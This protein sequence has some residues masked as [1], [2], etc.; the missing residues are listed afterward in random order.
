[1]GNIQAALVILN[2]NG[3]HLLERFLPG[4]VKY[5]PDT[6]EIIIADNASTDD[7]VAFLKEHYANI[8]IIRMK[9]NLGY[10]GGYN[11]ALSQ[12]KADI[13]ILLNSDMEVTEGWVEPCMQMFEEH[14]DVGALQPK[15]RSLKK[16]EYF[17]YAGAAGGFI[18]ILGFPFCRGRIFTSL[19]KDTGQF[20]TPAEIFWATGAALFVRAEVFHKPGGFDPRF[21]AHMEEI[22][23]CWEIQNMGYKVMYVPDSTVYHLGGGSL[24]KSNP[25]K[26]KYNF[27]NNLWM[28]ARQLPARW[29][30]TLILPRLL[31]D[32][33]AAMSFLIKGKPGD[34]LAVLRAH[35]AF[36]ARLPA[37]RKEKSN[38]G[39]NIPKL[40]YPRSIVWDYFVL[41]K[42]HFL[43]LDRKNSRA[44]R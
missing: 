1:M 12:V 43:Q 5:T 2:W 30:Y 40:I 33:L 8:R 24:P 27:R 6:V 17:E 36:F 3:R 31:L 34:S 29:F 18:D 42:K 41:G 22:D 7:S 10:A 39:K 32:I 38:R 19:E 11:H 15:I 13:Y 26:T 23:L 14:K 4:I 20:N 28:L 35:V 37:L 25:Q 16:K 21:F 44:S 9:E